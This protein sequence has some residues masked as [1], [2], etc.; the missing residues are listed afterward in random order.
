M[1]FLALFVVLESPFFENTGNI[2]FANSFSFDLDWY[3]HC[4]PCWIVLHSFQG[5][6]KIAVITANNDGCL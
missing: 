3:I 2:Y 6:M 1:G 5:K 4:C